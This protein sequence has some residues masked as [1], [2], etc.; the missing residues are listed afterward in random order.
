MEM[1][2]NLLYSDEAVKLEKISQPAGG[3]SVGQSGEK[4]S[5]TF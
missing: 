5:L 2:A 1:S 3:C 4:E